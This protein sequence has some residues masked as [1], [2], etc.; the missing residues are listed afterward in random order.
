MS[1][2]SVLTAALA[3]RT[4]TLPEVTAYCDEDLG[5]VTRIL[6]GCAGLVERDGE[7]WR[8]VDPLEVRRLVISGPPSASAPSSSDGG[9]LIAARML[10]AEETLLAC[11]RELDAQTRSIMAATATNHLRHVVAAGGHLQ[12]PWWQVDLDRDTPEVDLDAAGTTI[13]PARL[14][15]AAALAQLTRSEAAGI[16]V[17]V[18]FLAEA[19]L[20]AD[21]LRQAMAESRSRALVDRFMQL[22][23]A[24]ADPAGQLSGQSAA[25]ARLVAALAWMRARVRAERDSGQASAVLLP[26]LKG[27]QDHDVLAADPENCLYRVLGAL[28][29]GRTRFAVYLDL[30]ELLP[31]QYACQP[32]GV[33]LPG[34][35]VEAVADPATSGQLSDW[36]SRLENDLVRSPFGSQSALIG[37]TAYVL[38]DLATGTARLDC[39]VIGRSDRTR[40]ELLSLADVRV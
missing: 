40:S 24:V 17:T 35:I 10:L 20:Q 1:R 4:F 3:L 23:Q 15:V 33:L 26:L 39:G 38:E 14:R 7:R 5:A 29:D 22:A 28:P 32:T 6:N 18:A 36:A 9:R 21:Q 13:T 19:I 12:V 27:L 37:Q 31:Q 30:L 2:D 11:S 16:E 8:V 25:P 34:A